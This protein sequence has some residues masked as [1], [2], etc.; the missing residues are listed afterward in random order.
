MPIWVTDKN[1]KMFK[2]KS[3]FIVNLQEFIKHALHIINLHFEYYIMEDLVVRGYYAKMTKL[4]S[5]TPPPGME[6]VVADDN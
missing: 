1:E 4:V 3:K 5:A 6:I 2:A